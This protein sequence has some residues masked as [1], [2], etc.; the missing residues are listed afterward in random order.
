MV[1]LVLLPAEHL[2][3]GRNRGN[4]CL[5][6]MPLDSQRPR[7]TLAEDLGSKSCVSPMPQLKRE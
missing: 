4:S 5:T 2:W 3:I 1:L 7:R 6:A